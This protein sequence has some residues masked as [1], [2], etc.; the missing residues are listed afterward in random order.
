MDLTFQL[1]VNLIHEQVSSHLAT[2]VLKK[3]LSVNG[4][5]AG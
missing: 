3:L 5:V 4:K 1:T 2:S